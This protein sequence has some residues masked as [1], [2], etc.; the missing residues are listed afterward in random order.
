MKRIALYGG[1]FDPPHVGHVLS[2]TAVMN[3]NRVDEIWIVPAGLRND[4]EQHSRPEDRKTMVTIMLRTVFGQNE[5]IQMIDSQIDDGSTPSTT[6]G[7]LKEMRKQYCDHEFIFVIGA[8]LIGDIPN[9]VNADQLMNRE[10][11]LM[12][13]RPGIGEPKPL[14][15]Y[16][17]RVNIGNVVSTNCSSSMVRDMILNEQNIMGIVPSAVIAYITENG[18]YHSAHVSDKPAIDYEG[19]FIRFIN[20]NNWEYV[21]RTNCTGV[22]VVVAI[23]RDQKL[24]F[25]EQY[26][27]PVKASVIEFP[28]GL[29]NDL[30]DTE[31]ESYETVAVRE[32]LEET[33]FTAEEMVTLTT[34]PS[35][36]G[37]TNELITVLLAKNCIKVEEGG[38]DETESIVVHSVAIDNAESWLK[39][40]EKRGCLVDPK[41]YAG[42]Y[43]AVN[44]L[45]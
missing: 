7:L 36:A 19:K 12:V 44:Y 29:V 3:S 11:F 27:L 38:G 34:G 15:P 32:L 21:E 30:D 41:V 1:S 26:R 25:T 10:T 18:L 23:T 24:I 22:V 28:A 39:E 35:S 31:V 2:I 8:D 16:I 42:L 5:S 9:W 13:P 4:K 33:G 6:H 43:F 37:L 14:P 17:Q 45:S 40:S 20:D